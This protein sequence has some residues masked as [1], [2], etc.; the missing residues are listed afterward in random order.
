MPDVSGVTDAVGD[1]VTDAVGQAAQALAE[2]AQDLIVPALIG[3]AD[4][5]G[6]LLATRLALRGTVA[7]AEFNNKV[8]AEQAALSRRQMLLEAGSACWRR[9]AETAAGINARIMVL[10]LEPSGPGDPPVPSPVQPVGVPLDRLWRQLA[11][12]ERA[13][14]RVEAHRAARATARLPFQHRDDP[15]SAAWHDK[16]RRRRLDALQRYVDGG[17]PPE[18]QHE[19]PVPSGGA[20]TEAGAL[21][22]DDVLR[23]GARLLARLPLSLPSASRDVIDDCLMEARRAVARR[24][25]AV[26]PF[27]DEAAL[28][29]STESKRAQQ[30]GTARR[31]AALRLDVLRSPAPDGVDPLPD[32][33]AAVSVLERVLR[34][35]VPPSPADERTVQEALVARSSALHRAYVA[36]ALR[37]ATE[38]WADGSVHARADGE[39]WDF[40][41]A[42]WG[43][44]YWLRFRLTTGGQARVITM[45]RPLPP[46]EA[47]DPD[48][49]ADWQK[50]DAERCAESES[51]VRQLS[52]LT[53]AEGVRAAFAWSPGAVVE[54]APAPG[55][56]ITAAPGQAR[57]TEPGRTSHHPAQP[58]R[59][60]TVRPRHRH[61]GDTGR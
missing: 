25:S 47:G 59:R 36:A 30:A 41:P 55:L 52:E 33:S 53:E 2:Q 16:L 48:A 12:A 4:L 13:L 22:E 29:A 5:S 60:P 7:L 8:A 28:I 56:T 43:G 57:P 20:L 58:S 37:R 42:A 31:D 34:D 61:H 27:L 11:D 23:E 14:R 3:L 9:A 40:A 35:G 1:Q 51:Y 10:G 54:G 17:P 18:L 32:A 39:H 49:V 50:R 24:P 26:R 38:R 44:H 46:G 21:T 45:R 15:A 19:E 6:A